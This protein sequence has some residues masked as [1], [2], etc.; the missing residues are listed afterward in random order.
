MFRLI[1]IV[2]LFSNIIF[3][4]ARLAELSGTVFLSDQTND[5]SGVKI[6]FEAASSSA[7]SDS[8]YSNTDGSYS[9]AVSYTHL[10]LPTIL[11]V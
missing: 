5:H 2:V 1:T 3:S 8:T 7:T 11:L 4:Q 9:I 6:I 10:T